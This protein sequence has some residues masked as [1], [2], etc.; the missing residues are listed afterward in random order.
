MTIGI[1]AFRH[2]GVV[3]SGQ[4]FGSSY[5]API[6]SGAALTVK[7][8]LIDDGRL[9]ANSPGNLHAVMLSMAD[10]WH[11]DYNGT[12]FRATFGGDRYSGFGRLKLRLLQTG[13]TQVMRR[14]MRTSRTF[15]NSSPDYTWRPYSTP[16]PSNSVNYKCVL[17]VPQNH[18]PTVDM[19]DIALRISLRAPVNGVCD[20]TGPI[21]QGQH[22]LGYDTKHMAAITEDVAGNCPEVAINNYGVPA[23]DSQLVNL[24]CQV[25]TI[26]DNEPS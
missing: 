4:A 19:A 26:D 18:D 24:F 22:D 2:F 21:I 16:N 9:W 8:Y 23:G 3:D 11:Y 12:S 1:S 7:D 20:G 15:N 6:V 10:R 25:T 14:W 13:S 17:N 5:A